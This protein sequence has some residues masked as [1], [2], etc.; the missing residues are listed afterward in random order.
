MS[1]KNEN[2]FERFSGHLKTINRHKAMVT[3]GCFKSGLYWQGITHDLSKYSPREFIPGVRYY[4]AGKRSPI[5]REKEVRGQSEGWLHHKGRNRHH[6]DYWIDYGPDP[7]LGIAGMKMPKRYVAEMAVDRI[8]ASRNYQKEA[9]TQRSAWDYYA[10]GKDMMVIHPESR[11]LLEYLLKMTA[12]KGEE[13]TYR[14]IRKKL[15][16][17]RNGDYHEV[18]GKLVLD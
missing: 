2:V 1:S 14:Y 7:Q 10:K 12:V 18:G 16:K 4:E 15:M 8:C 9:Y 6:F 13:Y 11:F 3:V 17:N 5:N